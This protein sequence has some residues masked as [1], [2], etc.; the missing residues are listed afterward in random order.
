MKS[1]FYADWETL[2]IRDH[3]VPPIAKGEVLLKVNACGICGSELE[4]FK[5]RS[6]RRTPPLIMGHEFCGTI[7]GVDGSP[8]QFKE[9]QRVVSHSIAT[10]GQCRA[11]GRGE[12][13]LCVQRK[14]FGMHRQ[15]AF[16]EYLSVPASGLIAWPDTVA[17]ESACLA[18]PLANGIHVAE[19]LR[20]HAPKIVLIMGAGPIGLM[21]QQAVQLLLHAETIVCDLVPER[22]RFAKSLGARFVVNAA[23][24]DLQRMISDST[25]GEGV[26]AVVDAV[27]SGLTKKQSLQL[28]RPGGVV[29]WI[30]LHE[31]PVTLDSYEITV[32]EKTVYG[33]YAATLKEL[34]QAIDM[35]AEGK[36]D[37]S[38]WVQVFPIESGVEAFMRMLAGRGKDIKAVLKP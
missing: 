35:M 34:R 12:D 25:A 26:D 9:G 16:A 8:V 24:D 30:G 11:C 31:N 1:L 20:P 15:G 2:E 36:V 6:S 22:L 32:S 28:V 23:S 38:S 33:S 13:H 19:K 17:P 37:V 4:T 21:C 29:V 18:E 10:C 7:A 3:P 5:N 14:V 27:G